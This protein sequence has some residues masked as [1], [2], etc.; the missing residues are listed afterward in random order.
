[1]QAGLGLLF[2]SHTAMGQVKGQLRAI[3]DLKEQSWERQHKAPRDLVLF[4]S[5]LCVSS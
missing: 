1:M 2:C 4:I 5:H 3:L